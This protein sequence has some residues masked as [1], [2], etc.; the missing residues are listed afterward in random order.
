[1]AKK[2]KKTGKDLADESMKAAKGFFGEF[3]EFIS[4]GNVMDMA[5]GVIIGAAFKAIVDS[6]VDDILMPFIGIFVKTNSFKDLSV[7][8]GSATIT[9]GAFLSAVI[10]FIILA[11]ILFI[12]VRTMNK[13]RE[14]AEKLAKKNEEEKAEEEEEKLSKEEELLTEIRDMMKN[15]K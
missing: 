4:K 9:Y 5:V 14:N 6:L 2:E 3:R 13:I 7:K 12:M 8:V 1:M 15:Q 11:L 10:N